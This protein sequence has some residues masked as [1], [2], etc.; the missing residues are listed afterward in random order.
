MC[1]VV[2]V[3]SYFGGKIFVA[4][5]IPE[6]TE[7][8]SS[9]FFEQDHDKIW[10]DGDVS[11]CT[12][13]SFADNYGCIIDGVFTSNCNSTTVS[14]GKSITFIPPIPRFGA[15]PLPSKSTNA[16]VYYSD[17][18]TI[19]MTEHSV[20]NTC[21]MQTGT[22]GGHS[23]GGCYNPYT[24]TIIGSGETYNYHIPCNSKNAIPV[25]GH[26]AHI[27]IS[28]TS[29]T[30]GPQDYFGS[31]SFYLAVVDDNLTSQTFDFGSD[32][33][34]FFVQIGTVVDGN[35]SETLS[36]YSM[37][38]FYVDNETIFGKVSVV[39]YDITA[40]GIVS[41]K[42]VDI[43]A[44]P[45]GTDTTN[46][47]LWQIFPRI[48][49]QKPSTD[50]LSCISEDVYTTQCFAIPNNPRIFKGTYDDIW[51]DGTP[52]V[53][54]YFIPVSSSA[55]NIAFV[56]ISGEDIIRIGQ[57]IPSVTIFDQQILFHSNINYSKE[58]FYPFGLVTIDSDT[59]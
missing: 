40:E 35:L 28:F 23:G 54:H 51:G 22:I 7:T 39:S 11:S 58:G 15:N 59:C 6:D 41:L 53:D 34:R 38:I 31:N 5:T 4:K 30:D 37:K 8:A 57:T 25:S 36:G 1:V 43:T 48:L 47:L 49:V 12:L 26:V 45:P 16:P 18:L 33:Q 32:A 52:I 56:Q 13:Y 17:E 24:G 10:S 14:A 29:T 9:F 44:L 3:I 42:L 2:V 21:N 27:C 46:N 50:G 20:V 55:G 19:M